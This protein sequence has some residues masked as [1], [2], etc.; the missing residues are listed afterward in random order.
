MIYTNVL[1]SDLERKQLH[2][3]LIANKEAIVVKSE[4]SYLDSE[5]QIDD[6]TIKR[7]VERYDDTDNL[8]LLSIA[9]LDRDKKIISVRRELIIVE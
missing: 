6:W 5:S 2:A 8:F 3:A 9:V 7:T 1:S 4:K